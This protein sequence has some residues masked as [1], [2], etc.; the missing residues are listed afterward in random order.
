[1][2]SRYS[3]P[4]RLL[5]LHLFCFLW[6]LTIPSL[7]G[8]FTSLHA[9]GDGVC[10]TNGND[11][12]PNLP[13]YGP[14]GARRYCNGRV[15]IEVLSE[16]Q[17]LPYVEA[18]NN[19]YFG[20]NSAE[21]VINTADFIPPADVATAL[22]VV[23]CSNADLVGYLNSGATTPPYNEENE[24]QVLLWTAFIDQAVDNH[25]TALATL[26]DKDVRTIV[27][28]GAVDIGTVPLYADFDSDSKTFIRNRIN[29]FNAALDVLATNLVSSNPDLTIHQPDTFAFLD[30]VV[31]NPT[32]YDLTVPNPD[33]ITALYNAA[34]LE[35]TFDGPGADYVFWDNVHPTAKVQMHLAN[36]VQQQICPI[37]ITDLR[38]SSGNTFLSLENVPL[39]RNGVIE[40]L[41][42]PGPWQEDSSIFEPFA[43]G[44]SSPT[45]SF[46]SPSPT[47][48][49][50]VT[51]P[52]TWSWP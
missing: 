46:P 26:Y 44:S 47:R 12:P 35:P 9:F 23:W 7:G 30:D 8:S 20:H 3:S 39:E 21:L 52:V 28:P 27:L 4:V 22:V 15:W 2:A 41:S 18:N 51:F 43:T 6:T 25:Q 31:N 37:T 16:W 13:Y 40:G 11:S 34:P 50:R 24:D 33:A 29:Q 32:K 48:L 17:G 45:I 19:S 36:L 10:T 1:M 14:A 5:A 42:G 38:L 49:Q